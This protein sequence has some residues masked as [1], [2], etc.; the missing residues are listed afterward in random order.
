MKKNVLVIQAHPDDTE[1]WCAGTLSLLKEK[2]HNI[3]IATMTAGGLGGVGTS[4]EDTIS[5]RKEEAKKASDCLGASY[6]CLD[7]PDGFVQDNTEI[8]LAVI[9][10]IRQLAVDILITHL[11]FDYHADH[12]ETFRICDAAAMLATLNSV[13]VKE[14]VLEKNPVFYHSMPMNMTDFLGTHVTPD[15]YL[16]ISKQMDVKMEMLACHKSQ[17]ALMKQMHGIDDFF[18]TMA[19]FSR[20]I[21]KQ[22]N[23]EAAEGW[24]QHTGAGFS[25]EPVIQT[26]LKDYLI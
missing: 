12:R 1:L 21:G 7:Q 10:L 4:L 24:W 2:G 16:D 3:H 5:I 14:Y 8:R 19:E 13:P 17:I 11:P 20:S 6:T 15:F 25:S 22:N 23:V 9:S 26:I 18:G